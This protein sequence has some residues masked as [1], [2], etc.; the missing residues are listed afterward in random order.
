MND[1][2]NYG[3]PQY[4][5][6]INSSENAFLGSIGVHLSVNE[7]TT[8]TPAEILHEFVHAYVRLQ[9]DFENGAMEEANLNDD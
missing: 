7:Q 4:Q 2:I 5:N 9:K 3:S 8:S 6:W 1:E